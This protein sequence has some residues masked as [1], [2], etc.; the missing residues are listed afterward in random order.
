[1]DLKEAIY[2]RRSVR[3]YSE[4]EV[5]KALITELLD[6][7]VQAPS[8]LNQQ[9]WAFAMFHGR[10]RLR[11]Y[12]ERIKNHLITTLPPI[13]EVVPRTQLY[14]DP[15]YDIF[16]GASDLVV[17]YAEHGRLQPAEDCCLAAQNFMLAAHATGL[18]TC[19][20]GFARSW[21]NL[22][23]IKDELGISNRYESVF[24]MALGYALGETPP[25]PRKAPELVCWLWD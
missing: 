9:P 5:G 19:P 24:P 15:A 23:N 4:R 17:I 21:F 22:P 11:N 12:S 3:R 6:A 20:I 8:A 16:H 13:F 1:M 18:A 2:H 25:V 14:E 10:Q 7:A